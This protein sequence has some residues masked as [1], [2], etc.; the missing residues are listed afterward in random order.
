MNW[1][2]YITVRAE[3]QIKKL[4]KSY[5][6]R[7]GIAINGI[8][9]NPFIGDIEKLDGKENIWRRRIGS[10]RIFYEINNSRKIIYV[11]SVKRRTSNTY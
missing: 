2:I 8:E 4:P 11:F 10:Y 3:K 1:K 5:I 7:I 9:S 6:E